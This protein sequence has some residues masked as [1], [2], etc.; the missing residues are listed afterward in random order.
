M[1]APV[2]PVTLTAKPRETSVTILVRLIEWP[3]TFIRTPT[4][5]FIRT[6]ITCRKHKQSVRRRIRSIGP[7]SGA[8]QPNNRK[9]GCLVAQNA[10]H[11][12]AP[13]CVFE[14]EPTSSSDMALSAVARLE[15]HLA[16]QHIL[17]RTPTTFPWNNH[18]LTPPST[19]QR[20]GDVSPLQE[21]LPQ[22]LG[23]FAHRLQAT[24]R[25]LQRVVTSL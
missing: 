23:G 5:T 22:H 20:G 18:K 4:T 3:T 6:P 10:A 7:H 9:G 25:S 19:Q 24:K 8:R 17:F 11:I 15:L 16:L 21:A 2:F 12:A 13:C 1:D 14:Q